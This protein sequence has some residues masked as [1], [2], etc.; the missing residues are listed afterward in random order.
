M[1]SWEEYQVCALMKGCKDLGS[2]KLYSDVWKGRLH[3]RYLG[4]SHRSWKSVS[5]RLLNVW[6]L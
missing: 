3:P 4:I 6:I 5:D 2:L 1:K